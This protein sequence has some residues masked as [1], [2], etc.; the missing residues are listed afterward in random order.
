MGAPKRRDIRRSSTVA[1]PANPG[2]GSICLNFASRRGAT[3]R[4]ELLSGLDIRRVWPFAAG[5][6]AVDH[7]RS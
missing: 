2:C 5:V 3:C 7:S 6:S 4:Y 1:R